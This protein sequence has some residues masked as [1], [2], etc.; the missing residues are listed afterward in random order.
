MVQGVSYNIMASIIDFLIAQSVTDNWESVSIVDDFTKAYR[1]QLPIISVRT[2]ET[3]STNL[4][5]GARTLLNMY[6]V[7]FDIFASDNT[8]R[9]NLTDWLIEVFKTGCS[10]YLYDL[11]KDVNNNYEVSNKTLTGKIERNKYTVNRNV[12]IWEGAE[13]FDKHRRVICALIHIQ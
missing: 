2:E 11:T 1:S 8:E 4:E 6:S 5:I 13:L 3:Y 12:E 9:S 10:Y 7:Y